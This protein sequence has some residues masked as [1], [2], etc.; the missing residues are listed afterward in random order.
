MYVYER[1]VVRTIASIGLPKISRE[2]GRSNAGR[3][4]KKDSVGNVLCARVALL[5]GMWGLGIGFAQGSPHPNVGQIYRRLQQNDAQKLRPQKNVESARSNEERGTTGS[6]AMSGGASVLVREFVVEGN[7]RIS[8]ERIS[9]A[10][11]PFVGRELS[12]TELHQATAAVTQ[13]YR[14]EGAFVSRVYLPTQEIKDGVVVLHVY[15][16]TL[17]K[18]GIVV[19]N[20]G[21][22]VH[23]EVISSL[24]KSTL[25]EGE[26][27]HSSDYERAILL[28][29]DIPG[30]SAFGTLYPGSQVGQARFEMGVR[31]EPVVSGNLDFDNFGGHYTGQERG[32]ATVYVNS[33]TKRGDQI[34]LRGVTSGDRSNY[35]YVEY[36]SPI[37]S[38]GLRGG[39]SFD[40]LN[41]ELSGEYEDLG[42]AGDFSESKAFVTYPIIR[43]LNTNLIV[44]ATYSY[45]K[46]ND[47]NDYELEAR[48]D[49]QSG[50][51]EF[52][53]D[54]RDQF[55]NGGLSSFGLSFT[56]GSN[57]IIANEAFKA[58]DDQYVKTDGGFFKLNYSASRLQN[59][60]GQASTLVAF[61]GQWAPYNLDSTQKFFLGG[62][63]SVGGYPLGEAYGDSG[64][65]AHVDL[66]Y[67]FY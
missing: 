5:L 64:A 62:P 4:V 44:E 24:L 1:G 31:D 16:G 58:V 66:R 38:S 41:Y 25:P 19:K 11:L 18:G 45:L 43:R 34:T 35:G 61:N 57:T 36:N 49:I 39:G 26:V 10:L 42:S 13:M 63:Y 47:Y 59:L 21:Q 48:R 30:I 51:F 46:A 15:E 2:K 40:Y 17:E 56:G 53:G 9:S 12:V 7:S 33:P 60:I 23:T 37:G 65:T 29:N 52:S 8:G 14:E 28:A 20:E 50:V 3:V 67:D 32:G 6:G 55:A 22:R 27:I 54:H